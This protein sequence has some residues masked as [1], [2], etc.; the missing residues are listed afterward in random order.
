MEASFVSC[1]L[2]CGWVP[3]L[4][5]TVR[6]S[7]ALRQEEDLDEASYDSECYIRCSYE[8]IESSFSVELLHDLHV[9]IRFPC[10]TR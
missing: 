1:F 2:L 4:T 8:R 7:L 9:I 5:K 3:L 6:L 10:L